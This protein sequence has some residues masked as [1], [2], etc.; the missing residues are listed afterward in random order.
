MLIEVLIIY[1]SFITR[2]LY[3]LLNFYEMLKIKYFSYTVL[4]LDITALYLMRIRLPSVG[5]CQILQQ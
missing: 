2:L 3:F 5:S 1:L 4:F